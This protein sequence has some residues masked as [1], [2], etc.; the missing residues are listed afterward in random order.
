LASFFVRQQ[1]K[2]VERTIRGDVHERL[3]AG[4]VE[5]LKLLATKPESYAYF[6]EGKSLKDD[7][8]N[9]EFILYS[10]EIFA[11]YMENVVNQE[12]NMDKADRRVWIRFIVDTCKMAPVVR[13]FLLDRQEWYSRKLITIV[14]DVQ[15]GD[16]SFY[17]A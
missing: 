2:Q 4:S 9:R 17:A 12:Y 5:I 6:Y 7:D 15:K 16:V 3:T 8:P 11:N 13:E 1:L 14:E 10:A